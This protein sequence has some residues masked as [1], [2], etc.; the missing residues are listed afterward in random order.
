[1]VGSPNVSLYLI[2]SISKY[3]HVCVRHYVAAKRQVQARNAGQDDMMLV[4]SPRFSVLGPHL[5]GAHSST[6]RPQR[7]PFRD[8]AQERYGGRRHRRSGASEKMTA[9]KEINILDLYF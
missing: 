1:M 7:V 9:L 4:L 5:A 6:H 2:L 3:A 8:G